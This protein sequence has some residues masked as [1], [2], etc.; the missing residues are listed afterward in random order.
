M[1]KIWIKQLE[2]ISLWYVFFSSLIARLIRLITYDSTYVIDLVSSR[3]AV[4]SFA[5]VQYVITLDYS[6]EA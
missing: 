6:S 4:V 1:A 2:T 5:A 3:W